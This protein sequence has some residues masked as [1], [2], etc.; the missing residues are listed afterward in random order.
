AAVPL[1]WQ[2]TDPY[3]VVAHIHYVLI[4]INLFPVVGGIYYWFPKF[5][6][7]MLS[8]RLGWWNFWLMFIGFNVGFFPMHISGLLGMP[9]RVYTY[10][11]GLG[12]SDLNLITTIGAFIFALGVLLFLINV[13]YSLIAGEK[14]GPNPWGAGTLE[15]ATSSPPPHYNFGVIPRV[16]SLYPLWEDQLGQPKE[17]RS[18]LDKGPL[19]DKEHEIPGTSVLDAEP[20]VI[21]KMPGK[22]IAPLLM[23]LIISGIFLGLLLQM[24]WLA[25][26]A[27]AATIPAAIYWLWP[28]PET[29]RT[30]EA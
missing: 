21:L 28:S 5:A 23:A 11:A 19:L 26:A 14:A 16:A 13:I 9:R 17:L 29:G 4:G 6:G 12:W 7:R 30:A 24:W 1:D 27:T 2:L 10:P 18:E 25:G 15:W 3:F 8:E 20:D 22:S